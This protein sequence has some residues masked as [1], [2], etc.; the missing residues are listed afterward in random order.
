MKFGVGQ[1]V[2]RFEDATLITGHG[3]YTDDIELP[4][5]AHAH[6]LRSPVAHEQLRMVEGQASDAMLGSLLILGGNDGDSVGVGAV[7][8]GSPMANRDGSRRRET[9]RRVLA[10][11]KVRL[12]GETVALVVAETLAQA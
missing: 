11:R 4:H 7:P 5:T 6:V 1:P 10:V 3:R 9:P 8:A 2:Q 12:V